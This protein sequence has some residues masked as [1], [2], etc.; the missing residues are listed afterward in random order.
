MEK[1]IAV[2]GGLL[3]LSGTAAE[4]PLI[5]FPLILVTHFVYLM[6]MK[7]VDLNDRAACGKAFRH[8]NYYGLA[9]ALIIY[10]CN[11]ISGTNIDAEFNRIN[12]D[13]EVVVKGSS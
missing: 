6:F 8:S 10:I 5:Y 12:Q 11:D 3:V 7:K 13:D 9:V 4:M 1:L 2:S